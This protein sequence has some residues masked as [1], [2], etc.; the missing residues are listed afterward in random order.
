MKLLSL[1]K[2]NRLEIVIAQADNQK[3]ASNHQNKICRKI[4][5]NSLF[6]FKEKTRII[7]ETENQTRNILSFCAKFCPGLLHSHTV[8]TVTHDHY[9]FFLQENKKNIWLPLKSCCTTTLVVETFKV[10]R[11]SQP[12]WQCATLD[13]MVNCT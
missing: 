5:L 9:A 10:I 13:K 1:W 3:I 7:Q 11:K 2:S 8:G 4:E 6:F 12:L